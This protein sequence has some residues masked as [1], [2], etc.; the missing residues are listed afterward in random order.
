MKAKRLTIGQ[1]MAKARKDRGLNQC[2]LERLTHI[3]HTNISAY[4]AD[5]H[6][7]NLL[8]L[9]TLANALHISIDEYIGRDVR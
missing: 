2:Q 7:P 1:S 6:Y 4:E 3:N 5:R 8:T 9:I